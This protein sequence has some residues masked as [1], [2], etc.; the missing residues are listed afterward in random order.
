LV[1]VE[2]ENNEPVRLKF[3]NPAGGLYE[4]ELTWK[5]LTS[6]AGSGTANAIDLAYRKRLEAESKQ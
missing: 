3:E 4:E 6:R 2:Y 5:E 1:V